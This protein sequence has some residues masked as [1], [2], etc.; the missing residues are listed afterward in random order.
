VVTA[1]PAAVTAQTDRVLDPIARTSEVLFGLIMALTF[2]GT[3]GVATVPAY[4][5]AAS[6][7]GPLA[8]A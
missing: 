7:S 4:A 6:T 2:T 5:R 3:F 8:G 1:V